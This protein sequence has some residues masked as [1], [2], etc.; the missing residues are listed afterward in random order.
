MSPSTRAARLRRAAS[1]AA[2]YL[3][4]CLALCLGL[5]CRAAAPLLSDYSHTAWGPQQG[6]PNDVV[7]FAQTTDGWLWLASSNGLYRFDGVRFERMDS[8]QGQRL[9]SPNVIGLLGTPDG[10]L[11][12]GHR[13]GGISRFKDGRLRRYAPG[14]WLSGGAV[15]GIVGGPDGTIWAATTEGLARL[16]PGAEDFAPVGADTGLPRAPVYQVKFTRDGRQWV[17]VVGGL[18]YREPG[19]SRYRRAWPYLTLCA[20]DE[21]PDGTLWASDGNDKHYRVRTAPPPG[22]PVPHAVPGGTGMHFDRDGVMW[23]LKRHALERRSAPYVGDADAD[24]AGAASQQLGRANGISGPLPQMWF[25]DREGNIWVGTSGGIDRLRRNRIHPLTLDTPLDHPGVVADAGGRVLVGDFFRLLSADAAGARKADVSMPMSAAVRA[26][27][28]ALW[29]GNATARWRRAPSGPWRR[30]PHPAGMTGHDVQAMLPFEDG[31]MWV[32][33]Q[34]LGLFRVDG[35]RWLP[36]G[37]LPGLPRALPLALARGAAGEVWA[38]YVGGRVVRIDGDGGQERVRVYGEADGLALGNVQSL[39]TDGARLWA[40]GE[41]GVACFE[42]GRWTLLAAPLRGVSGMLRT[43]DGDLW[44][45]GATGLAR[46]GAADLERALREPGRPV[47]F[48]RFDALD[49]LRGSAEQLRP[50]P[51]LA[52][53]T[54]GRLWFATTSEVSSLDPRSIPRN[55]LAPPVQILAL[56]AGGRRYEGR[57]IELPTGTSELQIAYTALALSMPERIRFRYRLQGVDGG[58]RDAGTRRDA[59]YTNLAPGSYRFDVAAVN[60]DGVWSTSAAQVDIT[61]PPRFVQTHAFHALLAALGALALYG[62]YRLRLRQLARRMDDLLHARLAERARIARGLHDTLLQSVQSLIM[63]FDQ[64]ARRLPQGAEERRKIEQTLELADQLM[65]EGRDT[66]LDLRAAGTPRELGA[67]LGEYGRVL[68]HERLAVD[69]TGRPRELVPHVR[70]ELLAI[71]REALFNCARHAGAERVALTL[72][73]GRDELRI[74]VRDDG[75]G[76]AHDRAGH[77]GLAGMRERAAAIGAACTIASSP[78]SGTSVE[79]V[80]GAEHAYAGMGASALRARLRRRRLPAT[81]I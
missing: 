8:L 50:M 7:Q 13:F 26:P 42:H 60:E 28:G 74:T 81:S 9:H 39:L 35:D 46:I 14:A 1:A 41:H 17:A 22:D 2:M 62:L 77:Y 52:R 67:A 61:I 38:G 31:R 55:P 24:G 72:D 78:G 76:L 70:D 34:A 25:Q 40:G 58:W 75:C 19:A 47:A 64:Q 30:F 59:F 12:I 23:V 51:T 29:I 5:P 36:D 54:D 16:A 69:V 37:G 53:G 10:S 73:Y 27:D 48:E 11:W 79:L 71:A 80:I 6:A 33:L 20:M 45:H 43:P 63:F 57:R 44:L 21:A 66:I 32:S 4:F 68:L 3:T 15:F 56:H 65:S 18:Y 49:G